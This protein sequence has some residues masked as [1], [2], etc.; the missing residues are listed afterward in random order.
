MK[1]IIYF[2]II[3]AIVF[4]L[5]WLAQN[6]TSFKIF[7]SIRNFFNSVIPPAPTYPPADKQLNIFIRNSKFIPNMN[8][9]EKGARVT[10]YNED[11]KTHTVDGEG[12]GSGNIVPGQSFS[13]IFNQ[14]GTYQYYCSIHPNMMGIIIVQ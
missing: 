2:V 5:A 10:W 3:V 14:A 12:W 7:S 9:I 11:D 4:A 13:K 6:Y 1:K 8:G